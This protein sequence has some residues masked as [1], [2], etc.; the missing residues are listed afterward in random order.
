MFPDPDLFLRMPSLSRRFLP[1]AGLLAAAALA[2]APGAYAKVLPAEITA[3]PRGATIEMGEVELSLAS[4]AKSKLKSAG[5]RMSGGGG[6]SA[7]ASKIELEAAEKG[8]VIDPITMRGELATSGTIT[9]RRGGKSAKLSK[10]TLLPGKSG[11]VTAKVGSKKVTLG[12]LKGGKAKFAPYA[13]GKLTNATLKL[14]SGGARALSK[15]VG[16]GF[17][18]GTFAKVSIEIVAR[19]LPLNSGSAVVT[20]DPAFLSLITSN[21]LTLTGVGG[22]TV[23][24]GVVTM[25]MIGGSFDPAGLTGRLAFNGEVQVTRGADTIRLFGWRAIITAGQREVFAQINDAIAA[26]V[27]TIDVNEMEA[28]LDGPNFSAEGAK[29]GLTKIGT[30][31]LKTSFGITAAE[32]MPF[33]TVA[34]TGYTPAGE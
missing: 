34:M 31:A 14:S 10:I 2:L 21:G 6:A 33:G 15:A 32:N 26:P 7:S 30:A 25:P 24:G 11:K 20:L 3:L 19:E 17:S 29:L 28:R 22:A 12:S 18:A 16:G 27:G 1:T 4:G 5:V 13:D 8:T 23:S 9:L